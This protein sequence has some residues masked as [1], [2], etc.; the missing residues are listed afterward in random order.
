MLIKIKNLPYGAL[1]PEGLLEN[2]IPAVYDI[3][4]LYDIAAVYDIIENFDL[5]RQFLRIY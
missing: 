2:D 4:A 5:K 1:G 3:T